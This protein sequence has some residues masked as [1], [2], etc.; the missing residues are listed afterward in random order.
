MTGKTNMPT[1]R[2]V[3]AAAKLLQSCLTPSDPMECS[4]PGSSVHEICQARVLEWG[5]IAF[6]HAIL[7]FSLIL[8]IKSVPPFQCINGFSM[9]K[10]LNPCDL[11]RGL[12]ANT[13][14]PLLDKVG[15]LNIRVPSAWFPNVC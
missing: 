9:Y 2:R 4:L 1:K 8:Q 3:A 11:L 6:S 13:A 15:T 7:Q 14:S 10:H 12:F 5:A